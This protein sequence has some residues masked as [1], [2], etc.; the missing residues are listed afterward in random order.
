VG[1]G[2]Q[3]RRVGSQLPPAPTEFNS[4]LCVMPK[5]IELDFDARFTTADKQ[6]NKQTF[7]GLWQPLRKALY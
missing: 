4:C 6:T 2:A 1:A 7:I 5:W 3:A